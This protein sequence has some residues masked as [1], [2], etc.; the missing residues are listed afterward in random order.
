MSLRS[1]GSFIVLWP[2]AF[3]YAQVQRLRVWLYRSGWFRSHRLPGY[4]ISVGNIEAGGTG[5]S[6]LVV[7]LCRYLL[8]QG[9]HPVVLTRGYRSGLATHDSLVLRGSEVLLAAE[10]SGPVHCDE[11]RMQAM[12]LGEVP[13]IVGSK[14]WKAAQR[15]LLKFPAPTHWILDDGFQHL[16]LQRDLDLILLDARRPFDKGFCLPLGRLRER[17]AALR[18]AHAVIF[19]RADED[20]PAA[21]FLYMLQT[22]Q[23][24]FFRVSFRDGSP[25]LMAGSLSSEAPVKK[26]ILALGLARPERLVRS[27]KERGLLIVRQHITRDHERFDV[28]LLRS[29]SSEADALITSEKDYWRAPEA[30]ATIG[31]P[32]YTIPLELDWLEPHSLPKIFNILTSRLL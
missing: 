16:P 24:P 30:L 8:N 20:H 18:R 28:E 31:L 23:L 22:W 15:Y 4:V 7:A 6:P 1:I 21:T 11:A 2:F 14:R 17:P 13:I 27:L 19:T 32:V 26:W 9:S 3:L 25:Q 5:K 10:K 12:Q 29:W